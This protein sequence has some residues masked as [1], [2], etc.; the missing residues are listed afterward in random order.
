MPPISE[1]RFGQLFS[2]LER[3][4]RGRVELSTNR[5]PGNSFELKDNASNNIRSTTCFV[6]RQMQ[7]D[8]FVAAN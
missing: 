4:S 8:L 7:V 3:A 5:P 1:K 2:F 6:G